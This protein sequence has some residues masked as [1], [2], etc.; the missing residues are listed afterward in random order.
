MVMPETV[1]MET[2]DARYVP[3]GYDP[4]KFPKPSLTTDIVLLTVADEEL[5][6][7]LV[8]RGG[9][10]YKGFWALPGGFA[11]SA[12]TLTS[13][14]RRELQ[15]ET[16]VTDINP[17]IFGAYS[18]DGRDP[19]GWVVSVGFVAFISA[20]RIEKNPPKAADD[21]DEV[22]WVNIR[23]LPELAFDHNRIAQEALK[24]VQKMVLVSALA[25]PLFNKKCKSSEI[26][27]AYKVIFGEDSGRKWNPGD[28]ADCL[29]MELE[30]QDLLE[31]WNDEENEDDPDCV[32][33]D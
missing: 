1:A 25:K 23:D 31:R 33:K 30:A 16:G 22:R 28:D 21:A 29:S 18:E 7:L 32:W 27:Q 20:E 4:D 17:H 3:E 11:E 2:T 15:E 24:H 14:A 9:H 13:T 5:K 8:L 10:P 19:R 12:E 26:A 6:V